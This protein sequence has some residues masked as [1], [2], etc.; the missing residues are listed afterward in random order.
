MSVLKKKDLAAEAESLIAGV[1]LVA[2]GHPDLKTSKRGEAA[3]KLTSGF[4]SR[5]GLDFLTNDLDNYRLKRNRL[6]KLRIT[7]SLVLAMKVYTYKGHKI[8]VRKDRSG[9]YRAK[10]DGRECPGSSGLKISAIMMARDT[11]DEMTPSAPPEPVKQ[12]VTY[13]TSPSQAREPVRK[14]PKLFP[15]LVVRLK[16]WRAQNDISQAEATELLREGG[17]PVRL[18]TLQEWESGRAAPNVFAALAL[19]EFLEKHP[20]VSIRRDPSRPGPK[21]FHA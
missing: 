19:T 17:L 2:P 16:A 18:R 9:V 20:T 12:R 13:E 8:T 7:E 14:R 4:F 10:I 3:S 6:V 15:D 5:L 11:V 21:G 1:S